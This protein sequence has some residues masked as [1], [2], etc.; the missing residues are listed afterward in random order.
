MIQICKDEISAILEQL[1]HTVWGFVAW[2]LETA[3][4]FITGCYIGD[5]FI[6]LGN[7]HAN[8]LNN[9]NGNDVWKVFLFYI[10]LFLVRFLV[11]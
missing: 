4:F 2:T 10:L 9:L 6:N 7:E 3:L 11:I 8:E 1:V 5:K